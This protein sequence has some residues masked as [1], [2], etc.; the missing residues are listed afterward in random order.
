MSRPGFSHSTLLCKFR[1]GLA[2]L[3]AVLTISSNA[4]VN[5]TVPVLIGADADANEA[6]VPLSSGVVHLLD[7]LQR[8]TGLKL[9]VR[10]MQWKRALLAAQQGQGV[11][12]GAAITPE[13]LQTLRFSEPI[14]AE[15]VWLVT[16]CDQQ[17]PFRQLADLQGKTL[18]MLGASSFGAEIDAAKD[19][20]FKTDYDMNNSRARFQKLLKRRTDA[21]FIYSQHQDTQ[22]LADEL[23]QRYGSLAQHEKP[24]LRSQPFCVLPQA[25][26]TT[27]LHFAV[28]PGAYS[29]ELHLL[30][31]SLRKAQQQGLLLRI[32]GPQSKPR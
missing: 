10:K 30:D 1:L 13:R 18:G 26:A 6:N 24:A 31:L 2:S 17:F 12:Y 27:P 7:Y 20:L 21:V 23:N 19:Q 32:F 14:Y 8:D 3:L 11:L 28:A 15:Y 16:R 25:A 9:E 4:Q 29:T 5:Q 22:F